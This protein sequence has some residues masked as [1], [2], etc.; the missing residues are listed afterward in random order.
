[1]RRSRTIS[2]ETFIIN[3]KRV[4][5]DKYDYTKVNWIDH[6]SKVIIVCPQHGMFSQSPTTH[7]NGSGC[8]DC[9]YIKNSKKATT[10]T[11]EFLDK[12]KKVHGQKYIYSKVN[13]INSKTKIV[14]TCSI[15][16]DFSQ[17]PNNHLQGDNCPKCGLLTQGENSRLTTKEFIRLARNKYNDKYDYSKVKYVHYEKKVIIICPK[18]G[19][20][21]QT[22]HSHL[23]KIN[24]SGCKRCGVDIMKSK[25]RLTTKEFIEKA[26]LIHGNK[27]DYSEIEYINSITKVKIIC[28]KHG[29]TLQSPNYHLKN[30]G[31]GC[32]KCG[33]ER[34]A[35]TK[36]SS[37]DEFIKKAKLIHGDK[38]DYTKTNYEKVNKN[39][40]IACP[41]HG[42]FLQTPGSHLSG[43]NCYDCSV[44]IIKSKT[45][46]T[47][48]EFIEKA[49]LIHGDQYD[50]SKVKY[51]NSRTKITIICKEHGEFMMEANSHT[52][53][54]QNCPKCSLIEST[55][56]MTYTTKQFIEKAVKKHKG[57]YGYKKSNYVKS[58]IKVIIECTYHGDFLQ[59]PAQ[60]LGGEGCPH[61]AKEIQTIGDTLYNLKN[62][63]IMRTG[64]LYVI[65]CYKD[66]EHFF[67][68]GITTQEIK[69]R[70]WSKSNMPY[71]YDIIFSYETTIIDAY[72]IE[73]NA[74]KSICEQ[75]LNYLPKLY[76]GGITECSSIN[77][78]DIDD[79]LFNL[80]KEQEYLC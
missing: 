46:L 47:T 69:K 73:Q 35:L 49:K 17:T 79:N 2:T 76:F 70:F 23:A 62:N 13:Y 74:I 26:K 39:V 20:Q 48:K 31:M 45:R 3:A 57:L 63:N 16:G 72:E 18:H 30:G 32:R 43:S 56:R 80:K 10:S 36:S 50:Y 21:L 40:I 34:S 71:D 61:C 5:G 51:Q 22:P 42:E 6:K 66:D 27:Y 11:S 37:T 77:P 14:I 41:D 52:S 54:G 60:H 29:M 25:T 7:L 19:E 75:N 8:R 68:V 55:K 78:I 33:I 1:M 24:I 44:D 64:F 53:G 59:A 38:Y 28:P 67:K 4:H 9:G 15:H 65:E 58:N 12:A